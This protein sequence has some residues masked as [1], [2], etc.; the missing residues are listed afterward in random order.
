MLSSLY[1]LGS[2]SSAS[3]SQ[4]TSLLRMNQT[5]HLCSRR[6]ALS[7]GKQGRP[8]STGWSSAGRAGP[9]LPPPA[10]KAFWMA[11]LLPPPSPLAWVRRQLVLEQRPE[12]RPPSQACMQH[13]LFDQV[14]EAL[15]TLGRVEVGGFTERGNRLT[16]MAQLFEIPSRIPTKPLM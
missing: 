2:R 5:F 12:C 3:P 14:D 7:V 11:F 8:T 16:R 4:N 9:S 15:G 13:L 6:W 1:L 10:P